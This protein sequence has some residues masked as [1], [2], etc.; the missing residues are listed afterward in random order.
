MRDETYAFHPRVFCFSKTGSR[1]ELVDEDVM[2][3]HN[4]CCAEGD[5]GYGH[6]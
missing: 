3:G 1:I 2:F 5:R 4:V 6:V